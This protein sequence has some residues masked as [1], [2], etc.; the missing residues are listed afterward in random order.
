MKSSKPLRLFRIWDVVLVAALLL[1]VGLTVWFAL[2]PEKG[3]YAEVYVDGKKQLTLKLNEDR[4]VALDHLVIV[5]SGGKISVKDADCPDKIC[6]K[7]GAINKKGQSIVCLPN[8][9]VIKIAGKG[10]VEA[11]T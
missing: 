4:E 7:R 11:I 5:V 2:A 1:L 10:E 9:I 3:D 6:Q 8:R